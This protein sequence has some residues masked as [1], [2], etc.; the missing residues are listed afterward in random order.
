MVESNPV[1]AYAGRMRNLTPIENEQ[2]F[3]A[4]LEAAQ[5]GPVT[6]ERENCELAVLLSVEDYERMRA[7]HVEALQQL[8]A[9]ISAEARG[10]GL[11]DETL[12][13]L[14]AEGLRPEKGW[15]LTSAAKSLD[16]PS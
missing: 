14:L 7:T 5:A 6:I 2:R 12:H 10:N 4:L 3:S 11:T 13:R 1:S 9:Q 8:G 16:F 15:S